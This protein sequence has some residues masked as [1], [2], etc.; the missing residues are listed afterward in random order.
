MPNVTG[1]A[2][3]LTGIPSLL[4]SSLGQVQDPVV[5]T[6]L[7]QIQQWANSVGSITPTPGSG[8]PAFGAV[9]NSPAATPGPDPSST[10]TLDRS[11]TLIAS[12]SGPT[13]RTSAATR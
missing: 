12:A 10:R 3:G 7:Y 2:Q 6:A 9:H 11:L 8:T 5:Q 13:A 1:T 4:I